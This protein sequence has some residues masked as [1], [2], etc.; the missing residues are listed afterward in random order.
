MSQSELEGRPDAGRRRIRQDARDGL[1]A[2]ALS[3]AAS[4]LL[5]VVVRV[6]VWWLG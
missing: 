6:G 2:A 5:V 1:A 4:L 3:L